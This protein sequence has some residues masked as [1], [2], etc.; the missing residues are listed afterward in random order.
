MFVSAVSSEDAPG[1]CGSNKTYFD[2]LA[3]ANNPV[4]CVGPVSA[5]L[6][7]EFNERPAIH[8]CCVQGS[9][10]IFRCVGKFL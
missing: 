3:F 9:S 2:S 8:Y 5:V 10:S 1:T 6:G 7:L 4:L